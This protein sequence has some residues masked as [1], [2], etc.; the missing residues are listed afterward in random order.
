MTNHYIPEKGDREWIAFDPSTK[1][2]LPT[3]YS[4]S[5]NDKTKG[6]HKAKR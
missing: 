5:E 1:I 2:D 3:R 6:F 4:L